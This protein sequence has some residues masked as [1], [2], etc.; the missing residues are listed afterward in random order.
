MLITVG[1]S[2]YST[3]LVLN[4][5]GES[6]FGVFNLI[7][8]VIAMLAFLSTAMATSTQRYLSFYQGTGDSEMQKKVFINSW[9]LHILIGIIVVVA[10]EIIS[11][12]L[13]NGFLNIPLDR[14]PTAE[15]VYHFMTAS[16]FFTI[17][18]VPFTASLNAHEN[19][20]W[21]AVVL[22]IEAVLKLLIAL[23]LSYFLQNERLVWYGFLCAIVAFLSFLLYGIYCLKKYRECTINRYKIDKTLMKELGA[24][25]GW[26]LFGALS[27]TGRFQGVAIL[28]NVFM[29]T[30]VNAAYG[31]AYQISGQ[32]SSLATMLFR[33]FNPQIMKSEGADD[34]HRMLRLS[35][36]AS[37][38]GFFLVAVI[39][40]PCIFEM[41]SILKFWLKNVPEYTVA[42][43]SLL[44]ISVLINQQAKGLESAVQAT[45]KMK[46]H[47]TVVGTLLL[48]NIPIVYILLKLNFPV[49][50]VILSFIFTEI[51]VV[52]ARIL[53][54][55]R[56][57]GLSI[58]DFFNQVLLKEILPIGLLIFV[59][60]LV[61][62]LFAFEF[63]FLLTIALSSVVFAVSIY[64]TGLCKEEKVLVDSIFRKFLGKFVK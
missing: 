22:I 38:F 58:R 27:Y 57:A 25:A 50:S 34:R 26:S 54:V 63:R 11:P 44:L 8:G 52:V 28:L 2:L 10:L 46:L 31:I 7:A 60:W 37:K 29:G 53:I 40:V 16:V 43:C 4:Y 45:G 48:L 19:M 35:M 42:F 56:V 32:M 30:I 24:F 13:F 49:Y 6:D 18:A 3:R 64:F 21:I 36:M 1:I 55:K 15:A 12:F 9:I 5:L 59:S 14:I 51:L 61:K 39:A 62:Y 20:L 17:V 23:S 33:A 41:P 47:Q